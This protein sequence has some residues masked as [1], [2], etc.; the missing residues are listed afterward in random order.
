M[1]CD[2]SGN[3]SVYDSELSINAANCDDNKLF[4]FKFCKVTSSNFNNFLI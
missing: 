2:D 1:V 3:R 4:T